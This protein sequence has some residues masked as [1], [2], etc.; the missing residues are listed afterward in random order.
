[1]DVCNSVN[2]CIREVSSLSVNDP[3]EALSFSVLGAG[4]MPVNKKGDIL[5]NCITAL[6]N[7]SVKQINQINQEIGRL[8]I[9]KKTG[10]PS[11][12]FCGIN[13]IAW[14]RENMPDIFKKCWK[15]LNLEEFIQLKWGIEPALDYS[16]SSI[17][18]AMD[19]INSAWDKEIFNFFKLSENLMPR[20][21][22]AGKIIGELRGK[23]CEELNLK[24]NV[25]VVTGGHDQVCGVLGAGIF[26]KNIALD[27]TGTVE[28]IVPVSEKPVLSEGML[29]SMV[30]WEYHLVPGLYVGIAANFTAGSVLRWFRDVFGEYEISKAKNNN[31]NVYDLLLPKN[32]WKPSKILTLPHFSGSV[33]PWN[34]PSSKGVMLGLTLG[35]TKEEISKSIIDGITYEARLNI[36]NFEKSGLK[37]RELRAIGGACNNKKW[38]QLKSDIFGKQIK[39]PHI[40]EASS[41]GAAMLAGFGVGLFSDLNEA[42]KNMVRIK[43]EYSP[44]KKI[45]D[46]Y[47]EYYQKYKKIYPLLKR[48]LNDL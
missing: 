19:I 14:F 15:F 31:I 18:M 34:D 3:I 43:E 24:Q 7:R 38:L 11:H 40:T 39:V 2:D 45:Q 8:N 28:A 9:Y 23:I 46:L 1:M 37:I 20:V 35:T 44:R 16:L 5:Y 22:I 29:N 41:L 13:K 10:M 21:E 25:K 32:D 30:L 36:E 26:E 27:S 17:I 4:I 6:D 42:V 33:S 47:E 12:P 48:L